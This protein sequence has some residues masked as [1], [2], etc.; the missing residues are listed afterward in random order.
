[1]QTRASAR[2]NRN[3][4]GVQQ[5]SIYSLNLGPWLVLEGMGSIDRP[6]PSVSKFTFFPIIRVIG[7]EN[8]ETTI[9]AGIEF[10]LRDY[11]YWA[12]RSM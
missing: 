4:A 12:G 8:R 10:W 5:R 1:M 6:L 11:Y 3:A 7:K 9:R 2:F